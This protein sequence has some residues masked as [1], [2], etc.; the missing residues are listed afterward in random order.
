MMRSF[1]VVFLCL[2]PKVSAMENIQDDQEH[3]ISSQ[4]QALKKKIIAEIELYSF[5]LG[6]SLGCDCCQFF[7]EALDTEEYQHVEKR[8]EELKIIKEMLQEP[9]FMPDDILSFIKKM[10]PFSGAF[11]VNFCDRCKK[12]IGKFLKKNP[13][14][15]L[16]NQTLCVACNDN[17]ATFYYL[18]CGHSSYCK[19]CFN[20]RKRLLSISPRVDGEPDPNKLINNCPICTEKSEPVRFK[21]KKT[22]NICV[23]C[24]ENASEI[25]FHPCGHLIYCNNCTNIIKPTKCPMCTEAITISRKIILTVPNGR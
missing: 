16:E 10:E 15:V 11:G 25:L 14:T 7:K 20:E 22:R 17:R 1:I 4:F 13:Q 12:I 3:S 24:E 9:M 2:A 5:S 19:R 6:K 8:Q 23:H 18:S 21:C